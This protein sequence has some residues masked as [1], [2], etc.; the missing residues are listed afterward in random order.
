MAKMMELRAEDPD[1]ASHPVARSGGERAAIEAAIP[2][3]PASMAARTWTSA[4]RPSS[5]SDGELPELAAKPV[6]AGS[7]C[8]FQRHCAWA[9]FLGIGFKFNDFIQ[10]WHRI[11]VMARPAGAAST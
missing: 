8:N 6:I 10:A 11:A 7:G 9:I 5:F 4:N 2:A 3:V 1:A